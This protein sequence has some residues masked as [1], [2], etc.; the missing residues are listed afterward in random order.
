[1]QGSAAF[2]TAGLL[3]DGRVLLAGGTLLNTS[4]VYDPSTNSWSSSGAL[5]ERRRSSALSAL[6][7]GQV[8]ITGG[9]DPLGPLGAFSSAEA[10]DASTGTWSLA[11]NMRTTRFSHTATL[12]PDGR[13]LV[14]GGSGPDGKLDSYEF[15][16]PS[17][18]TW[19]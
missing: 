10:R 8:L 11:G 2:H 17:D 15:Y 18:G 6:G 4:E 9:L 7:D 16:D 5:S 3:G 12:L 13:V 14:V 19:S 1:M